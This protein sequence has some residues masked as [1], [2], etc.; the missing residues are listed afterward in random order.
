MGLSLPAAIPPFGVWLVI[1]VPAAGCFWCQLN[2]P[3]LFLPFNV[4]VAKN[5]VRA[6]LVN[7]TRRKIWIRVQTR[8]HKANVGV[9][10]PVTVAIPDSDHVSRFQNEIRRKRKHGRRAQ[11]I[12]ADNVAVPRL[13]EVKA[14]VAIAPP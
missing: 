5:N 6:S 9:A 10:K 8:A 13:L 11:S 3:G 12:P 4:T 14:V 1:I 7:V 2:P